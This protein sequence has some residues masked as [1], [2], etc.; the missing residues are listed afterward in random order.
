MS[1]QRA[2]EGFL[3]GLNSNTLWYKCTSRTLRNTYQAPTQEALANISTQIKGAVKM[4]RKRIL[5]RTENVSCRSALVDCR[6]K[7][8][9]SEF[10][11]E[12]KDKQCCVVVKG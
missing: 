12:V 3:T 6:V 10:C 5:Y 2:G 4:L 1:S 11:V 8:G 7:V 9:A